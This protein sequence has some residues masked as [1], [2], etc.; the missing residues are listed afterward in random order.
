MIIFKKISWIKKNA[1]RYCNCI[2]YILFQI[3]SMIL[4]LSYIVRAFCNW[5]LTHIHIFIIKNLLTRYSRSKCKELCR[6][7]RL[8]INKNYHAHLLSVKSIE[9]WFRLQRK[10]GETTKRNNAIGLTTDYNNLS[11]TF[12]RR[13]LYK[14]FFYILFSRCISKTVYICVN[15]SRYVEISTWKILKHR[16]IDKQRRHL[17]RAR[18]ISLE[19]KISSQ[20]KRVHHET[21]RILK[22]TS[23]KSMDKYCKRYF[24]K[25]CNKVFLLTYLAFLSALYILI[26]YLS[27]IK[28]SW[29][30][31]NYKSIYNKTAIF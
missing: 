25:K 9:K 3:G 10:S 29:N 31:S 26:V 2:V 30:I 4:F 23:W 8:K 27:L 14:I 6:G 11:R 19:R 18:H 7:K 24:S 28:V 20:Y 12:I 5:T 17:I 22:I 21:A 15:I 13:V 1:D 16:T